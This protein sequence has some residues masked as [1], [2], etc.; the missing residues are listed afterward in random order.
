VVR[1]IFD[2]KIRE[3][4][5]PSA[6]AVIGASS[7][8]GKIGYEVL[9]NIIEGG[10]EGD[11]YPVNPKGG[12]ILGLKVYQS[13]LKLPKTPELAVVTTPAQAALKVVEECG[14]KGVK[15][16]VI[17]SAGFSEVGN[18]DLER[19][20]I[21]IAKSY[22]V[23]IIGPNSAGVVN[24]SLNLYACLEFRVKSGPISLIS[25][26]GAIGGVL[27]AYARASRIGFSKFI[28]CGNS[29]D[30]DESE[31]LAYLAGDE[32]T[33]VIALYMES[34]KRGRHLIEVAREASLIK[35]VIALKG[36]RSN[37]GIRAASSHTGS[38][39]SSY[40]VY[41]GAFRQAG[42]IQVEFLED[43]FNSAKALSTQPPARG[44][45]VAILTN[46]GGPGVL[47]TDAC[48]SL[49]LKVP[50]PSSEL[51]SKL[52]SILPPICSVRNPIDLTAN[53]S[54][55]WYFES[56]KILLSS[57]EFDGV[58]VICVPPSFMDSTLAARAVIDARRFYPDKPIIAS[59]L[60]GDVVEEG[61]K[62]LEGNQVPNVSSPRGAA[63]AMK[64][65]V[66]YGR[67]K[68]GRKFGRRFHG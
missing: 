42:I 37:A 31:V 50:E 40:A 48:E 43:L 39:A 7:R 3:M 36:G 15:G 32:G 65:L 4:L 68:F 20:L 29:A 12:E 56:L 13:V 33:K 41:A 64:V 60:Y 5:E 67:I 38:L 44:D 17:I 57:R 27:F 34:V 62:L 9:K 8:P 59:F 61:V 46:S 52:M 54:Y 35:P 55:D 1:L 10:F 14:V 6:V 25:Q 19:R 51:K 26:S 47:T 11:V 2:P 63:E 53:A 21:S 45:R 24:T 22:G 58:I 28:S 30:V 23:R 49:G 18:Y 66:D 16:A